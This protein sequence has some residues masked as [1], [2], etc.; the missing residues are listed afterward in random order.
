[1]TWLTPPYH[2]YNAEFMDPSS[3]CRVGVLEQL[4]EVSLEPSACFRGGL[5]SISVATVGIISGRSRVRSSVRFTAGLD[6]NNSINQCIAS[7]RGRTGTKT[8]VD[9]I[10]PVCKSQ[11]RCGLNT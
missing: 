5:E 8:R 11:L 10:T 3:K 1:M 7:V 4:L 2:R 9:H 6:P